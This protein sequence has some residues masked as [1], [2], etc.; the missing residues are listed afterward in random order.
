VLS[1]LQEDIRAG[2]TYPLVLTFERAG[3]VR[4]EV[5]VGN[6]TAPREDAHAG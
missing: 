1:G 4:L 2:L 3:E 6:A 5:P